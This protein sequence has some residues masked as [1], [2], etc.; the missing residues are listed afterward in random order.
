MGHDALTYMGV[1]QTTKQWKR[2]DTWGGK[3]VENIVQAVARDCLA[4]TMRRVDQMGYRIVMHV[5][6]EIIV[7][8]S[9]DDTDALERICAV[10]GEPIDWAPGLLLRGDGYETEYYKKD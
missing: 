6:D 10:M 1:D 9:K 3:I 4:E 2:I 7:D 8:A 5:H